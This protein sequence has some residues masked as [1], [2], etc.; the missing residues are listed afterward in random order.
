MKIIFERTFNPLKKPEWIYRFTSTFREE[1]KNVE[2]LH[3]LTQNVIEGRKKELMNQQPSEA[4]RWTLLDTLL[5]SNEKLSF[6][7]ITDEINS[8]IH[9]GRDTLGS[10]FQ[11]L[12]LALAKYEKIQ[13]DVYAEIRS[14][15]NSSEDLNKL[16]VNDLSKLT[17]LNAVIKET[18]RMFPPIPFFGRKMMEDFV[19]D[20]FTFPKDS[21]VVISAYSIG[22]DPQIF[23]N[24]S[25]FDPSRFIGSENSD[26]LINLAFSV[27]KRQCSGKKFVFPMT[28]LLMVKLLLNF[29]FELL[30]P[31]DEIEP[32]MGISLSLRNPLNIKFTERALDEK[33]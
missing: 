20:K 17:Y 13:A 25:V 5:L 7:D 15:F 14:C 31:D 4:S 32:V 33:Q 9:G 23:S 10:L 21:E 12:I 16:T 6:Q 28:K 29:K 22:R 11:F 2:I 8:Y 1:K 24:P 27:G 26:K 18:L 19:T 3:S 30:N